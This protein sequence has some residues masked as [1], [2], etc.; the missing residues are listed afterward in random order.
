MNAGLTAGSART[1]SA[2]APMPEAAAFHEAYFVIPTS[3]NI[4]AYSKA[5]SL[6]AS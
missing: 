5:L 6:S 4:Q 1:G 2:A 3:L